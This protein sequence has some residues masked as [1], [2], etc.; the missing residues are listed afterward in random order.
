M[1]EY[2]A[3]EMVALARELKVQQDAT[4]RS[5]QAREMIAEGKEQCG[6]VTYHGVRTPG[7]CVI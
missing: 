1:Q 7:T 6:Q 2:S 5:S 3:Q 4:V